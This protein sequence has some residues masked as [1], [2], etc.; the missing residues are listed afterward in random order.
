MRNARLPFPIRV[1]TRWGDYSPA[2]HY[3]VSQRISAGLSGCA[4]QIR[5]VA[6]RIRDDELH[7]IAQRRCEIEVTTTDAG[8]ISAS[9]VGINLFS[10]VDH[11]VDAVVAMLRQHTSVEPQGEMRQ[12]IA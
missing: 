10:L 3:H 8:R 11:T 5:A 6:V 9:S 1:R 7:N 4:A 2:L 12:R